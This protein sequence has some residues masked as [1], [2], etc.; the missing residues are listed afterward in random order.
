MPSGE[1]S[2]LVQQQCGA[3]RELFQYTAALDDRAAPG[4]DRHSRHQ[5]DRRGQDQR[6]RSRDDQHGNSAVGAAG[7]PREGCCSQA[8]QQE[9]DGVAIGHA[10]KRRLRLLGFRNQPDNPGIGALGRLGAGDQV[11]RRP[12]VHHAA[13][14]L[15]PLPALDRNR[16]T[17][18]RRLVQDSPASRDGAVHRHEV[19]M[20]HQEHVAWH[21]L[22]ERDLL[23]RAVAVPARRPRR[24]LKQ[25]SEVAAGPARRPAFQRPTAGQHHRY[26]RGR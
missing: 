20:S 2:G 24:P 19:T 7:R 16:L 4:C 3:P 9:P 12:G 1:R 18:E 17:S 21:D 14:D 26:H 13:S 6:A 11:E 23:K 5:R 8:D 15:I 22:I 25:R 10:D